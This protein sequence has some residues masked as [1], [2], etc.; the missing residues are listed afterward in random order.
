MDV[1]GPSSSNASSALTIRPTPKETSEEDL[2]NAKP[3]PRAN[4]QREP[5]LNAL[6]SMTIDTALKAHSVSASEEVENGE[7]GA[8]SYFTAATPSTFPSPG[9][10]SETAPATPAAPAI[11][12]SSPAPTPVSTPAPA[13][14]TA[15]TPQAARPQTPPPRTQSPVRPAPAPSTSFE[16]QPRVHRFSLMKSGGG[17]SP[18]D[19]LFG[20]A[21]G[22]GSKCDLCAKRLGWKPCLECDDC[23]LTYVQLRLF[24][25]VSWSILLNC[26]F[27]SV[28]LQGAHEMR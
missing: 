24:R 19:I 9:V 27:L 17:W 11:P 18:L 10:P 26:L 8:E 4:H 22:T 23:S 2:G 28:C 3:V 13:Q 25:A 16:L 21:L 7:A 5:N 20:S 12:T 6:P 15:P 14:V 1:D